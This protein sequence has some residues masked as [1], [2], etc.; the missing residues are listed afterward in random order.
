MFRKP[1]AYS[2][3][4]IASF[5]L[6][7]H[8]IVPH[9]HHEANIAFKLSKINSSKSEKDHNLPFPEHAHQHTDYL[10]VFRQVFAYSPHSGR[11]LDRDDVCPETNLIDCLFLFSLNG[12]CVYYPP[13]RL[14][15]FYDAP[16]YLSGI[17][18]YTFGL[19]APPVV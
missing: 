13:T 10:A 6:L 19:R 2:F 8:D 9:H 14:N 3:I 12:F 5:I 11:L 18:S 15:V 7:A 17:L 1:I 4:I 16:P